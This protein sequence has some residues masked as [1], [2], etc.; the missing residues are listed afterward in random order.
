MSTTLMATLGGM[1][2]P[3]TFIFTMLAAPAGLPQLPVIVWILGMGV[4]VG[5]T[6]ASTIFLAMALRAARGFRERIQREESALKM[7]RGAAPGGP[8]LPKITILKP[9]HGA[10]PRLEENLESFFR[11]QYA[12][13]EII[14]GCRSA[15]DPAVEVVRR[16]RERYPQVSATMVF[17]GE[18]QWPSAKVW[19]LEKMMAH[20]TGEV[21]VISDSDIL[22]EEDFLRRV[23]SPFADSKVGLV[24]CLY[25]GI[26][27]PGVWSTLEALGMS[28]EMP[29]GVLTAEML[30]GM[31]F[32]LGAVMAVRREALEK[33]GG[34]SC[35]SEYY[36]DDFVLGA[37]VAGEGYQVVLST[38]RVGHVLAE[39]SL[40]RS[41]GGQ[42]RWMQ[43]TRYSRPWGHLGTGMT[44]GT[45]Y[46]LLA[47]AMGFGM[48]WPWFGAALFAWSIV[49]RVWQSAYVGGRV[50]G[51]ERAWKLCWLYP[52][53][54]LMGFCLWVASYAGGSAFYWRGERYLFTPG[55][56]IVAVGRRA[57]RT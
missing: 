5:G 41:L 54:D 52:V 18:P 16:L 26:P 2:L 6:L 30:E 56:R 40:R 27:A 24:T 7:L 9:L 21:L 39:T 55:G 20:A 4:A 1:S 44:F 25:R 50:I 11:Q 31:R 23:V 13:F 49:S 33:I 45:P 22:V 57:G 38:V 48:G 19:S 34:I 46:G 35:A 10:E 42:L 12:N 28:V 29:S 14:F 51:D 3:H 36:S 17:S 43:S 8:T 32:A 47:L 37:R 53:R 15:D